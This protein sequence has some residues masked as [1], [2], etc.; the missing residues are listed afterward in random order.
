MISTSQLWLTLEVRSKS[1]KLIRRI[2]K[3][4]R[5]Y[6]LQWEQ[7][8]SVLMAGAYG[9]S[10]K[11][12][13][14]KDTGAINRTI[15]VNA[16]GACS[17]FLATLAGAGLNTYGIV[18][19]TG[20]NAPT[21]ADTNLQTII[22]HG[23]GAGQLNYQAG[24]FTDAAVIGANVDFILTRTWTNASGNSIT[25]QEVGVY[26]SV[27]DSGSTQRYFDVIRDLGSITVANGQ[28]LTATYTLR[29][30]V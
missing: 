29:T 1:G 6:L 21:N 8:L 18:V 24:T 16:P 23:A 13:V 30:T 28:T 17:Q 4:A 5:S 11:S 27:A 15:Q 12:V 25:V 3:P 19:G 7:L 22:A 10:A 2:H 14:I 20:A 26:V 9:A